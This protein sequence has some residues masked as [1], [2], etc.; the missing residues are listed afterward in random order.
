MANIKDIATGLT[1]VKIMDDS[2]ALAKGLQKSESLMKRFGETCVSVGSKMAVFGVTMASPCVNV[3]AA[4][5]S[6]TSRCAMGK[7][8]T[9]ATSDEFA[10]PSKYEPKKTLWPN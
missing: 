7:D 3:S 2:L 10:L 9:S 6:T 8:I 5:L 1:Y 4:S